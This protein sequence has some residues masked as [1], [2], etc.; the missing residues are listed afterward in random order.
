MPKDPSEQFYKLL[1]N[2][3]ALHA[4]KAKD[5]GSD[6][7]PLANV[8]ASSLFGVRPWIGALIR[9]NDKVVRL[10]TFATKGVL[11][12]ESAKDSML[13]IAAYSLLAYILYEEES[14]AK[15]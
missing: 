14:D 15:G 8:R 3:R 2:L 4:K 9:L 13:D 7:D 11:Q 10:Q 6:V 12:N 5:Y 1:E